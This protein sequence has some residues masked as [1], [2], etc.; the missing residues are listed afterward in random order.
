VS[1]ATLTSIHLLCESLRQ[2]VHV[3]VMANFQ[4]F[5]Q[6]QEELRKIKH[7]EYF[8]LIKMHCNNGFMENGK[9]TNNNPVSISSTEKWSL[10][11]V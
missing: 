7:T 11:P 2:K 3:V 9:T 6:H 5:S 4:A 1:F 8:P 10:G